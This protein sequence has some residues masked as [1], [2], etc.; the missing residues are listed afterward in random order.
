MLL[1]TMKKLDQLCFNVVSLRFHWQNVPDHKLGSTTATT[2]LFR[3]PFPFFTHFHPSTLTSLTLEGH[4]YLKCSSR[5]PRRPKAMILPALRHVPQLETLRLLVHA[6]T[7]AID[8]LEELDRLC[9]KLQHFKWSLQTRLEGVGL[10]SGT[11]I[12]PTHTMKK[13][14][15]PHQRLWNSIDVCTSPWWTYICTKYPPIKTLVLQSPEQH[16]N[17]VNAHLSNPLLS[18]DEQKIL[19]SMELKKDYFPQLEEV[20]LGS[21]A[22]RP[23]S[24]WPLLVKD[25]PNVTLIGDATHG[26]SDWIH[27]PSTH[28][29]IQRLSLFLIPKALDQLSQCTLLTHLELG[30]DDP[31]KLVYEKLPLDVLLSACPILYKL[32]ASNCLICYDQE[33]TSATTAMIPSDTDKNRTDSTAALL[34][35]LNTLILRRSVLKDNEV[36][37][38][39]GDRCPQLSHLDLSSCVWFVADSLKHPTT[40]IDMPNRYFSFL[41]ISDPSL[42]EFTIPDENAPMI[43]FR[44]Y[45]GLHRVYQQPRF[46]IHCV[47]SNDVYYTIKRT[48][49]EQQGERKKDEC[50]NSSNDALTK[51][52][53][54]TLLHIERDQHGK[55]TFTYPVASKNSTN[56]RNAPRKRKYYFKEEE[57]LAGHT[58]WDLTFYCH[59]VDQL[60]FNDLRLNVGDT[61]SCQKLPKSKPTSLRRIQHLSSKWPIV[62]KILAELD[63]YQHP[64][65]NLQQYYDDSPGQALVKWITPPPPSEADVLSLPS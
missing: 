60:Y 33:D 21:F 28:K 40:Q 61:K 27:S 10:T 58:L 26:F 15:L 64:G 43:R 3:S 53:K 29:N 5:S 59:R 39:I 2:R 41:R 30:F 36:L 56:Q 32:T 22:G 18:Q 42:F 9:P 57:M 35:R 65:S 62:C 4:Q 23:S 16:I 54:G 46:R 1:E 11:T 51:M 19:G 20:H 38:R 34:S 49:V 13:L 63:A 7:I 31:F 12:T 17:I 44:S 48:E 45:A 25:I 50:E 24:A 8:D 52:E 47:N 37:A 14:V 6:L 55:V